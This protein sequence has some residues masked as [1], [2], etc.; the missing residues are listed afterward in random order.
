MPHQKSGSRPTYWSNYIMPVYVVT[1]VVIG[2]HMPN[3][4][5]KIHKKNCSSCKVIK[6]K[7]SRL[8]SSTKLIRYLAVGNP[9]TSAKSGNP[10]GSKWTLLF[11]SLS[12]RKMFNVEVCSNITKSKS[13]LPIIRHNSNEKFTKS[14]I[15]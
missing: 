1:V 14:K 3:L 15:K 12:K 8:D 7:A 5:W 10:S 2:V 6:Q 11:K 9:S 4:K 13:Y